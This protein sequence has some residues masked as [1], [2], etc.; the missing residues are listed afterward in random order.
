[1]DDLFRILEI[2]AFTTGLIAY[3]YS[4]TRVVL[5]FINTIIKV[6]SI[7]ISAKSDHLNPLRLHTRRKHF[8]KLP[9]C[10]CMRGEDNNLTLRR[11]KH[12]CFLLNVVNSSKKSSFNQVR[13]FIECHAH[14]CML[15][16]GLSKPFVSSAS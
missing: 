5:E 1:M 12:I 14:K 4:T 7:H 3:N 2:T 6:F 9:E 13:I 16:L 15:V 11:R 8:H 10:S